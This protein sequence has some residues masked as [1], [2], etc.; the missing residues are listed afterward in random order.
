MSVFTSTGTENR[1][2]WDRRKRGFME[3]WFATLNHGPTGSGL[4]VRYTLTS[5]AHA[6]PYCELW[7][8]WFDPAGERSFAG[9]ERYSIDHLGSAN[10]RDDGALVRIGDAWMSESHLEG[11]V[12]AATRT[13]AWSLDLEPAARTFQHIP[14]ALRDRLERRVSALCSPNL[15]VPFRGNVKLDGEGFEFDGDR[16][17][18]SHRW[19]ARHAGT[20]AWAHCESFDGA[21]GTLFEGLA[22]RTDIARIPLPTTSLLYLRHEGEDIP[23]NELRWA[24]SAK[25]RYEMPMWAFHARN[26]SWKIIGGARAAHDRTVQVRYDDPNGSERFCANSEIADLAIELYRDSP[27]GWRHVRSLISIR[28]AHLEFGRRTPFEGLAVTL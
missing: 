9:K 26:E 15:S 27:S 5:P 3:V 18:Q 21:P 6:E 24:L 23:F 8:F 17:C 7:A 19:G 4:W 28:A 22:A 10:G 25:S 11:E 16:G 20:W 14:A 1:M 12:T 2:R 13:L